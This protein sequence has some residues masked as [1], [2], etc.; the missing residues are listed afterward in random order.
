MT[1][2][3]LSPEASTTTNVALYWVWRGKGDRARQYVDKLS[4]VERAE[5]YMHLM[6]L[7]LLVK[8]MTPEGVAAA[9]LQPDSL[10][11]GVDGYAIAGRP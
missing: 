3:L 4:D 8:S 2:I 1:T 10:P 7:A 6:R 9:M 11:D 5:A